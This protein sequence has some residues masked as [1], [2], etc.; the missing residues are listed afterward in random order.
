MCGRF[1]RTSPREAIV[2]EFGVDIVRA[3]DLRS[4]YNICPGD[5]VAAIVEH[6][7]ERRLGT[8]RWSRSGDARSNGQ[9]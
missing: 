2:E 3:V 5:Q 7:G 8:L 4:R 9:A 6:R 1:V